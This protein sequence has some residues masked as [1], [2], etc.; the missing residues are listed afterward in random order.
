MDDAELRALLAAQQAQIAEL[1]VALRPQPTLALPLAEL[2]ARYEKAQK[3]RPGWRT[4]E[5]MLRP[6]IKLLGARDA[7]TLAVTDWAEYRDGR[8]DLA[9][10]SRNYVLAKLKAML[11]WGVAEGLYAADPPLCRARTQPQKDHRET[12]PTEP[13]IDRLL[14]E[15]RKARERVIVLCAVDSGL[16][17]N[18]IRQLQWPWIDRERMEIDLPNWACKGERGGTVP[19]T[20]RLLAAIDAMPRV[21]RS[22]YVLANPK[23]GRPY[24]KEMFTKWWRELAELAGLKAAPGEVRVRLHD[25]RH[26][27]GRRAVKRGV[28]IEVVSEIYRHAS[29]DQT[30]DYVGGADSADLAAARETFE[31]GI[32]RDRTR[33]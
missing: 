25:G 15:V 9:A 1:L 29:L 31:A 26:A 22:E 2:Y 13:E 16:R 32:E 3:A 33:R 8:P 20:R 5:S 11:R 24:A 4:A 27:F 28:R 23:T 10:G 17:R 7:R 19:A 18:E 12:S 30:L 21:L 6:V 14:T